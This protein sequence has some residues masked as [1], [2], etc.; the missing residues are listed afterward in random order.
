MSTLAPIILVVLVLVLVGLLVS[1]LVHIPP[2]GDLAR[3]RPI[4]RLG[5]LSALGLLSLS[6][7]FG[8]WTRISAEALYTFGTSAIVD[9]FSPRGGFIA[10]PHQAM[11]PAIVG[12]LWTRLLLPPPMREDCLSDDPEVCAVIENL[13]QQM[14]AIWSPAVYVRDILIASVS[15]VACIGFS[16]LFTRRGRLGPAAAKPLDDGGMAGPGNRSRRP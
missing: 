3:R 9:T 10:W 2:V 15:A 4:A 6:L 5:T 12:E 13:P 1:L 8:F 11:K 14:G 16:W 7:G